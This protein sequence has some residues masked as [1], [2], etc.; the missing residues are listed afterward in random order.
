MFSP[1]LIFRTSLSPAESG[2]KKTTSLSIRQAAMDWLL[3]GEPNSLQVGGFSPRAHWAQMVAQKYHLVGGFRMFYINIPFCF[4]ITCIFG[5]NYL[6]WCWTFW[7]SKDVRFL[8]TPFW[9]YLN[10]KLPPNS[11][12]ELWRVKNCVESGGPFEV[13]RRLRCDPNWWN[14]EF[15]DASNVNR[16]LFCVLGVLLQPL[17]FWSSRLKGQDLGPLHPLAPILFGSFWWRHWKFQ[18]SHKKYFLNMCQKMVEDFCCGKSFSSHSLQLWVEAGGH[19]SDRWLE[20]QGLKQWSTQTL[21]MLEKH[22][23]SHPKSNGERDG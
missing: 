9:T 18:A 14:W 17:R 11:V 5:T 2:S 8:R 12:Q 23:G 10:V 1:V 19:G 20:D 16:N 4:R 22:L 21:G 15:Q 3:A 7:I 6:G 13:L